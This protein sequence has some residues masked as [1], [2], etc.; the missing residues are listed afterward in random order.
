MNP[1]ANII[2]WVY[3]ITLAGIAIF[4][5]PVTQN[6]YDTNKWIVLIA[7]AFL[8]VLA[9]AWEYV[10][11]SSKATISLRPSTIGLGAITLASLAS[12]LFISP[13]KV[14][15]ILN[16]FG[17]ATFLAL[18]IMSLLA[19]LFWTEHSSR[20]FLWSLFGAATILGLIAIYQFAGLG[21]RMFPGIPYLAD[22]LWTPT[23]A[24]A[25][26]V[27]LFMLAIP[28]LVTGIRESKTHKRD[29]HLGALILMTILTVAGLGL[30][31]WHGIPRIA[32]TLLPLT[33]GWAIMLEILKA[34][35]QAL[36]GA[37]AD[38]FLAAFSAGRP[39][40]VNTSPVWSIRFT[41][42]ASLLLH[43]VTIYGL[44]GGAAA[45]LF[46][47]SFLSRQRRDALRISL[48]LGLLALLL[49]PPNLA[50][51]VV[52]TGLLLTAEAHTQ[53]GLVHI[54]H[55]NTH[56]RR[57]VG[58]VLLALG[59]AGLWYAGKSYRAELMFAKSLVAA[60][61]NN[62]TQTYNL[63]I[64]A[65]QA[66]P[67]ISR[68][69]STFSQTN[70]A[71]ATTLARS[72][73]PD[74]EA[75]E[76]AK[77]RDRELVS[78]LIQQAIREAKIAATL[79]PRNILAW[80]NLARI[81]AQMIGVAQGA[82]GW[83]VA[84]FQ[85]AI[86]ID[87]SNPVLPLELGGVYVQTAQYTQAITQFTRA[88]SLK[89]DYA[90]AWFNLSNAYELAGDRKNAITAME[91][92]RNLVVKDSSDEKLVTGQLEELRNKEPQPSP[93]ASPSAATTLTTPA[94][95]PVVIPPLELPQ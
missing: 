7:V 73:G 88:V 52:L 13:N 86:A 3:P 84:T 63:Q 64:R 31:L 26:T 74:S 19:P 91:Q 14:E 41:A 77:L 69:H 28:F 85:Q 12:L 29:T 21:K 8:T 53:T 57:G 2:S 36:F 70:L 67:A 46:L 6:F 66:N 75:S 27:T 95:T 80:E 81:Y 47:R 59:A 83:A 87:P 23:G 60:G 24:P 22:P 78:Q 50:L 4:F 79:N 30:T 82:D 51:L 1:V 43:L 56:V 17:P 40:A 72:L 90:N 11:G 39:A 55:A 16:P 49:V 5:L 65:I 33:T 68:Y 9:W 37:G 61:Q 94:P 54:P 18:T 15:A 92:T 58:I 71:I 32:T 20:R 44:T 10:R 42:N 48:A 89:P 45:V 35:V 62:G 38:N 76:E 25:T 93:Q 34:P